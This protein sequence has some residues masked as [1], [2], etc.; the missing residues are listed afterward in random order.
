[1]FLASAA[2]AYITGQCL[3]VDG[4]YHGA[5]I[6]PETRMKSLVYTAA[7]RSPAA[8]TEPEPVLDDGEVV[9]QIE[10]AGIC[11]SDMHAYHGHDPRRKPAAGARPRA[12]RHR[13]AVGT[14]L[15]RAGQRV[16]VNPLITCGRCDY[17]LQG[18]DNLCADR[19]MVGMT[20]ARAPSPSG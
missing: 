18:R 4:G 2:S 1:M 9:L 11:G 15:W 20:P 17:C 7:Q 13:A 10:A 14:P 6:L 19:T 12:R 8:A 3:M 16:T 5:L